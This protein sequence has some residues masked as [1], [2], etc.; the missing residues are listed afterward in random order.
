MKKTIKIVLSIALI[1]IVLVVAWKVG[2]PGRKAKKAKKAEIEQTIKNCT[3]SITANEQ[4]L[5]LLNGPPKEDIKL[6]EI[7]ENG[8]SIFEYNHQEAQIDIAKAKIA[9]YKKE[10]KNQTRSLRLY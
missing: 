6:I 7:D 2:E 8:D 1:T 3:D 4:R 10:L 5:I 9:A